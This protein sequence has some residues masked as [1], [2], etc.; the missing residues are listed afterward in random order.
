M[1]LQTHKEAKIIA[2]VSE[3][4][5]LLLDAQLFICQRLEFVIIAS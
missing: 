3:L 5:E 1:I 4:L 2:F